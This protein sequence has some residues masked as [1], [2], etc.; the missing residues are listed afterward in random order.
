[1]P[2]GIYLVND[3]FRYEGTVSKA[4]VAGLISSRVVQLLRKEREQQG[5]SMNVLAQR[6]GLAQ[7]TISRIEH[8]LRIP[9][10]E[11]L[12]RMSMVLEVDLGRVIQQAKAGT[13][14]AKRG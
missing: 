4:N 3:R 5:M 9:N 11:T 10:L 8:E 12:L 1:M 13:G 14:P 6:S 2:I 7:S